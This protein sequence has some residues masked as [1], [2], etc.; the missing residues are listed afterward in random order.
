M[1]DTGGLRKGLTIDMNGELVRVVDYQ[2]VKQGRGS[3]FVRLTLRNI[4]TGST[5]QQTFQ[6]GSK[7][8]SVRL[9]RQRVQYLYNDDG[10]Y[11]FMDLDTFEQF[12]LDR[13][14]LGDAVNY[15]IENE[16]LD[17]LTYE[18]AP[19]DVEL[20]IT[21]NLTVAETEP[22]VKGDTAAGGTKPARLETGV[23]VNV[24]LFV[25]TGDVVKVDTRT[26]AYLERVS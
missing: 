12:A 16:A 8:Q 15:L 19:I 7:F 14:A 6:A 2:H 1:I 24:P 18:G 10:H 4:R 5:T 9:E 23:S 11:H 20:P 21:V 26:G 3:A 17:L 25:N 22:G 13:E